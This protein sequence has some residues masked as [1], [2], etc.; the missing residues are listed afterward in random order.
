MVYTTDDVSLENIKYFKHWD[1]AKERN[2]SLEVIAFI[3]AEDMDM[4]VLK[5]FLKERP[6]VIPA[7]HCWDHKELQEGWREDQERYIRMAKDKL[8]DVLPE[9][10]LYRFPGFRTLP[11]SE[12]ILKKLDFKGIAH[13]GFIKW[14]DTGKLEQT[15]DTHCCDK[16]INPVTK[17]CQNIRL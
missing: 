4:E 9:R 7:V 14:F 12:S 17:V 13:Q 6:W 8:I 3:I 11:K 2:P 10:P 16:F 5:K 15:Y 1:M